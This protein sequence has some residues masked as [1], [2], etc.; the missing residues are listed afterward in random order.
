MECELLVDPARDLTVIRP[1]VDVLD[2]NTAKDFRRDVIARVAPDARVVL[3]LTGVQFVDSA[4]CGAILAC[5]RH[6]NADSSGPGELKICA[7]T[8]PVRALFEMVRLHKLV[9]I[10][11]SREEALRAFDAA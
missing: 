5:L 11:G 4:G 3:D 9:E 6:L 2:A 7:A 10:Y 1:G 8:N